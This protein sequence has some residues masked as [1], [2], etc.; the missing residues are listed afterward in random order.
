MPLVTA[1]PVN[2]MSVSEHTRGVHAE[3]IAPSLLRNFPT[4][5]LNPTRSPGGSPRQTAHS[6]P[7]ADRPAT[8]AIAAVPAVTDGNV[9]VLV[10]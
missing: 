9:S 1:S 6:G 7:F 8:P 3:A 2:Q 4:L 10:L 5:A